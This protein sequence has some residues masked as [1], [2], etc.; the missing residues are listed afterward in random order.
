MDISL[1]E[2]CIDAIFEW[3]CF[4]AGVRARH[5]FIV[6]WLVSELILGILGNMSCSLMR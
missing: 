3:S 6:T 1:R 2:R 5:I 4:F